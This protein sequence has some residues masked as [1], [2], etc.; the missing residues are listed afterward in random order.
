MGL[1]SNVACTPFVVERQNNLKFAMNARRDGDDS[2]LLRILARSDGDLKCFAL[3]SCA[4]DHLGRCTFALPRL[5][6]CPGI[7]RFIA[8]ANG[9]TC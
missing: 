5:I 2:E 6:D 7:W 3:A 8:N 4:V 1:V 9:N